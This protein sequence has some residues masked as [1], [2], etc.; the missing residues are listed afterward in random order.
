VSTQL[1]GS[2]T[3]ARAPRKATIMPPRRSPRVAAVVE[4]ESSALPLLPPVLV[5]KIFLLLPV[6]ARARCACVCRGW[7]AAVSERSLWTRL[8]VSHTSGVTVTVTDTLLRGAAAPAGG[9]L[10]AMHVSFAHELTVEALLA[11]ATANGRTLRELR[12]CPGA[13]GADAGGLRLLSMHDEEALLRAASQLHVLDVAVGGNVADARRALRAEGLLA[14]LRVHRLR[15]SHFAADEAD[16]LA[17]AADVASHAWLQELWLVNRLRTPAVLDA[18]VDAALLARRLVSVQFYGCG[19]SPASAPALARLL[20]GSS[21]THLLVCDELYPL[22]DAPASTLLA[23]ALRV[24]TTL[25]VLHLQAV[26]LWANAAAAS[27]LLGALTVH[28]SL[29][30]LSLASNDMPEVARAACR[31]CAGRAARRQRAGA[32]GAAR[33]LLHS[34]RRGHG[35]AARGAAA[36]HAPAR[37]QHR[38]QLH[39]RGVCARRA[40]AGGARQ[41]KPAC[42]AHVADHARRARGGGRRERPRRTRQRGPLTAESAERIAALAQAAARSRTC[43]SGLRMTCDDARTPACTLRASSICGQLQ[44]QEMGCNDKLFR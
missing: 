26:H 34:D 15:V 24:N 44:G 39:K 3:R 6:D 16:V 25:A 8:D 42:L 7:R 22:L 21:I 43:A 9:E 4:R 5:Q 10:Q 41:R 2:S 11:V 35:A 28:P 13:L 20:G 27:T 30:E 1:S 38:R 19:L 31:C 23:D 17:L 12:V 18:W 40:A 32:D 29:R 36:Q 33:R 37:A 14:P